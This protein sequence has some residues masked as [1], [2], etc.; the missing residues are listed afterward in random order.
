MKIRNIFVTTIAFIY[1]LSVMHGVVAKPGILEARQPDGSTVYIRMDGGPRGHQ[2]YTHDD[3]R[4]MISENGFYVQADENFMIRS[5]KKLKERS[6]ALS[7]SPAPYSLPGLMSNPFPAKGKQNALVIL[8]DFPDC[9]FTISNPLQHFQEMLNGENYTLDGATGSARKYYLDNSNGEFDINFDIYGPVTVT[10]NFAYYGAND[11]WGE[12]VNPHEMILEACALLDN[13]IDFSQY[14]KNGDGEIDMVYVFYAGY[15]EADGGGPNTIWPHSAGVAS[16]FVIYKYFDNK[17]LNHYACSMEL[18]YSSPDHARPDGIG[19]F[20]HEFCHVLGIPDLY[21]TIGGGAFTPCEWSLMDSGS[22]NNDSRTPPGLS[23]F[24]RAAI[25]WMEPQK[26]FTPGNYSLNPLGPDNNEAFMISTSSKNEYFLLE[27]RQQQGWDEFLPHHGML[28]WHI[29]YNSTIWNNNTVNINARHQRVDLVEADGI[30]SNWTIDGDAFPGLY[31]K[32]EFTQY[33]TPALVS[34]DNKPLGVGIREIKEIDGKISFS[35]SDLQGI[36]LNVSSLTLHSKDSAHLEV[37][38]NPSDS[39]KWSLVWKSSNPDVAEVNDQGIISAYKSGKTK[40]TVTV[41]NYPDLLATCLVDVIPY[42]LKYKVDDEIYETQYYD[43]GENIV[44]PQD[45]NKEGCSFI[46][47]EGLPT[48][49]PAQDL[50]VSALFELNE[51]YITYIVDGSEYKKEKYEY[52]TEITP[53]EDPGKEG[54]TFTGWSG[55]PKTMPGKNITVTATFTVNSYLLT[56]YVDGKEYNKQTIEYGAVI[57][58]LQYPTKSGYTFSGWSGFPETMPANDIEVYGNFKVNMHNI[59]FMVDDAIYHSEEVAY[60]DLITL[61][62]AP[63]KEGNQFTGW[64]GLPETMPDYDVTVTATFDKKIYTIRYY[65]DNVLCNEENWSFEDLI[66]P[67]ESPVK[68]GYTF[69][70]W[71]GLPEYMPASDLDIYG[72]FTINSHNVIF[73][74][75]GE[76]Y[77]RLKVTYDSI[78]PLPEPPSKEGYSFIGWSLLPDSMPDHE[79]VVNALFAVNQYE[80]VYYLDKM[81]YNSQTWNYGSEISPLPNPEKPGHTFSGWKGLP[82]IM[83][84]E[85][86]NVYGSFSVN[87]HYVTFIVE[88]EEYHKV[89]VE[90]GKTIQLPQS[91]LKEGHSFIGWEGLTEIMPDKD[92]IATA[93]FSINEY[94]ITYYIDDVEYS[95]QTFKYGERIDAITAPSKTGYTFTGWRGLPETM[96]SQNIIIIGYFQVNSYSIFYYIDDQ[97]YDIQTLEYGEIIIPPSVPTDEDREFG[98]WLTLIPTT[99]PAEDITIYGFTRPLDSGIND[100][101]Y[102]ANQVVDIYDLTGNIIRIGVPIEKVSSLLSPG[103]YI[104]HKDHQSFKIKVVN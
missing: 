103:F 6:V 75:D 61:P 7:N 1:G 50:T 64:S 91:P 89:T 4:L 9:P 93:S 57:T 17:L 27:N 100:I 46:G 79:V 52:G 21:S 48:V 92:I 40:I 12:D 43:E 95:K 68:E 29:D 65:L 45:P 76:E 14:D 74:I 58:P 42:V 85:N 2:I 36:A 90:Y 80:I 24:E 66:I 15:G 62:A 96:P 37:T 28:V 20:C 88:G 98:G 11:Y 86:I 8:V 104:L 35:V 71:T 25:G 47:W 39:N 53:P 99:M 77:Y 51:Y 84:A 87:S 63:Q 13:D 70:G 73:I 49:M 30:P 38:F 101:E 18:Q 31:E 5:E 16:D 23:S 97:L 81:V 32:T 102:E 56:Y 19:T 78:I 72:F 54:Y 22:Y 3:Q 41:E 26:L 59:Y 82:E 69:S 33:T 44:L 60:G 94:E 83:P 10:K 67:M 34:W 55:L